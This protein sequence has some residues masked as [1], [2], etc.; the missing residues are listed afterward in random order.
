MKCT[1]YYGVVYYSIVQC[2]ASNYALFSKK[3][4]EIKKKRRR[5]RR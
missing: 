1:I 2:S 3:M 4:I 5:R